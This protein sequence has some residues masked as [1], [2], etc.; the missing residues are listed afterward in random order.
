MIK[1]AEIALIHFSTAINFSVLFE[2][3]FVLLGSDLFKR[4]SIEQNINMFANYFEQSVINMSDSSSKMKLSNLNIQ[5]QKYRQ[6]VENY[7][8]H[9]KAIDET[10]REQIEFALKE[11]NLFIN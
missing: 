8:K 3:P 1:H 2:K 10:F 6:F 4:S 9:P 11:L 5:H 7:I